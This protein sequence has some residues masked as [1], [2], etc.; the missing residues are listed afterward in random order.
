MVDISNHSTVNPSVSASASLLHRVLEL[1]LL[2]GMTKAPGSR[3]SIH[4]SIVTN[5]GKI[6][7]H[8]SS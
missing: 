7:S 3:R 6:G 2:K 4:S 8:K 5:F 1:L